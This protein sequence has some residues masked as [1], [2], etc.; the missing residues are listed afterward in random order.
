MLNLMDVASNE[1]VL[2]KQLA[3]FEQN[4]TFMEFV[5]IYTKIMDANLR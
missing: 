1:K 2:S 4:P 3:R 5:E